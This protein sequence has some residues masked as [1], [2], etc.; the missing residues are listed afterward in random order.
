MRT[1]LPL[2]LLALAAAASASPITYTWTTDP[3]YYGFG[4][5]IHFGSATITALA[6][7]AN[8]STPDTFGSHIT[9]SSA[10]I[11]IP[12][13]TYSVTGSL[14]VQTFALTGSYSRVT[15]ESGSQNLVFVDY[16]GAGYDLKSAATFTGTN[17]GDFIPTSGGQVFLFSGG[18]TFTAT[19]QAVPE[20]AS[21]A[22]LAL[23]GGAFLRRRRK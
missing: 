6:D 22:A 1:L 4:G 17:G 8:V 14:L 15:L 23:G 16:D 20:P 3:N 7:T 11:A 9:P 19:P 13:G 21:M 18:V 10:T 5:D 12:E 2:A